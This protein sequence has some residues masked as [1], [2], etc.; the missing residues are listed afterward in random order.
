MN[1]R[2]F[3]ERVATCA[4]IECRRKART[5]GSKGEVTAQAS[6]MAA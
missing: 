6:R 3:A 4:T 5:S 2:P 1:G